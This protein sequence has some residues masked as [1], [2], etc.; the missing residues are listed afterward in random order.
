MFALGLLYLI[1]KQFDDLIYYKSQKTTIAFLVENFK[2]GN[3]VGQ[4]PILI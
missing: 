1:N 4:M 3:D 2:A